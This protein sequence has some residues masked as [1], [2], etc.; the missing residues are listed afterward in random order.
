MRLK[1]P[2]L[3]PAAF[4]AV[5]LLAACSPAA[6]PR[7]E[8]TASSAPTEAASP[9]S[10]P[11]AQPT[12]TPVELPTVDTIGCDTMLEPLFDEALRSVRLQPAPKRWTQFGFEPTLAAIECPWGYEGEMHSATYYAW[13]ALADGEREQFLDLTTANG[14]GTEDD[15][16]GTWIVSPREDPTD[17]GEVLVTEDWIAFA[18]TRELVSVIV[19]TH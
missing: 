14:Y 4:A 18:P 6:P 13:S 2:I 3:L 9:S 17:Q 12:E 11:S 15:S 7:V 5:F 8:P 19:W 16:R 1:K 10:E